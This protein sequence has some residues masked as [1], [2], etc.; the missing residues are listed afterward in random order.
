MQPVDL[1]HG[2]RAVIDYAHTDDALKN[3]LQ[4]LKALNPV[5][6]TVVFGCGGDRDRSKR[7]R[8]GRIAAESADKVIITSDNPRTES[9]ALIINDICCGIHDGAT[10]ECVVDR[11]AAIHQALEEAVPGEIVLIAG[12]GH[13]DY[14][15]INGEKTHLDDL[16]EVKKFQ[17]DCGGD[18]STP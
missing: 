18:S 5:R 11:R 17:T 15:D 1:N 7:P 16:E 3:V 9:P 6:L 8:M 13:E 12:K 4:T 14:Q 2:V 10:Y